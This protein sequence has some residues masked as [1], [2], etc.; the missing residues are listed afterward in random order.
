MSVTIWLAREWSDEELLEFVEGDLVDINNV[1]QQQGLPTHQEAF[2]EWVQNLEFPQLSWSYSTIHYLRYFAARFIENRGWNPTV[3]D[4]NK[5]DIPTYLG[6]YIFELKK[7]HLI[8]HS[9]CNGYYLP[10]D[11][12]TVIYDQ[13]LPGYW[14]GSSIYLVKEL[15]YLAELLSFNL[16]EFTPNL[17][18][19]Y[20]QRKEELD[21]KSDF[22]SV[23]KSLLLDLY[24][25]AQASVEYGSAIA[26]T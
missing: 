9:D 19:V 22:L 13:N 23:H 10:I 2:G 12:E 25:V 7:S 1:L 18:K 14:L 24:N 4:S 5:K 21:N 6:D 3:E 17:N 26:F 8:C 20:E 16:G 11:F 15:E